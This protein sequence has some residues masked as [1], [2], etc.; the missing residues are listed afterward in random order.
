M[1]T[2]KDLSPRLGAVY[3]LRG[4][5]RTAL[6]VTANRYVDGIG[7]NFA[8]GINPALQ[9]VTVTRTWFDGMPSAALWRT[10]EALLFPTRGPGPLLLP[11]P[12]SKL[13]WMCRRRR[14]PAGGPPASQG[15][16]AS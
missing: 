15:P 1:A 4:D 10:R 5:G 8:R 14:Y 12:R 6:K 2:W 13:I 3:D 11:G 7:T 9:N 16:T